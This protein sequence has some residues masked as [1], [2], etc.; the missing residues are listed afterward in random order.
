M[1]IPMSVKVLERAILMPDIL[2]CV[3]GEKKYP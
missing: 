3:P 2:E 1:T